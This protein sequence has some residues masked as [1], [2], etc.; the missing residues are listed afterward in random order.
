ML[1]ESEVGLIAS[2]VGCRATVIPSSPHPLEHL[3]QRVPSPDKDRLLGLEMPE[4]RNW[5]DFWA[6]HYLALYMSCVWVLSWISA[7]GRRYSMGAGASVSEQ[8]E[9]EAFQAV[10]EV[11]LLPEMLAK[12]L[13]PP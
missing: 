7:S 13:G 6:E 5:Q 4:M 12:P 9:L 3:Q 2:A 11:R 1:A 8:H 10:R